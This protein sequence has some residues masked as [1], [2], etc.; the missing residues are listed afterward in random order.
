MPME[1]STAS[2]ARRPGVA[3]AGVAFDMDGTLVD[4]EFVHFEAW[5][6]IFESFG[7]GPYGERSPAG[8]VCP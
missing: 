5:N 2:T 6:A 8:R 3:L 1:V 7:L 4:T